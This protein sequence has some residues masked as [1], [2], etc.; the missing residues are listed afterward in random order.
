MTRLWGGAMLQ[1]LE[2]ADVR[3]V[4]LTIGLYQA[5]L[6]YRSD[7]RM[8]FRE[9][10]PKTLQMLTGFPALAFLIFFLFD[11]DLPNTLGWGLATGID[12]GGFVLFN[13]AALLILWCHV[14][15]G[16]CWSGDLETK[17]D[18]RLVDRGLYRWIRHPLYSSYLL[19]T[20]GLF[21]FSD[22]SW[23]GALM[24]VYFLSVA[25]RTW[26][27]EEMLVER[28]GELYLTYRENT[29]R[30]IPKFAPAPVRDSSAL[31]IPGE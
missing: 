22:N 26:R 12:F 3:L 30:F 18:H 7:R 11:P 1:T 23:L 14:T 27:E 29:G 10:F 28:L 21:L 20:A 31:R 5:Y 25:S 16:D 6:Q 15:L 19:L 17:T 9:G 13:V 2:M 8:S 4:L 24:L